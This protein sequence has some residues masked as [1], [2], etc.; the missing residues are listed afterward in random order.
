MVLTV[1]LAHSYTEVPLR[2]G[3]GQKDRTEIKLDVSKVLSV[4]PFKHRRTF[5]ESPLIVKQGL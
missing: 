2:L 4:Y 5:M 1:E 3:L